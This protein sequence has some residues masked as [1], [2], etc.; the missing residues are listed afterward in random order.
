MTLTLDAFKAQLDSLL[1]AQD[2]ELSDLGRYRMIKAAVERYSSDAPD[3]YS[4]DEA[5]D[6][7]SY[8]ALTGASPVLANWIEGFSRISAIQLP[9]PTIAS[10]EAPAYLEPDDWRDDYEAGGIRYLY[11]PHHAPGAADTM[12]ITYTIPY[13]WTA[14]TAAITI[15]QTAHGLSADDYI[16]QDDNQVWH[17]APEQRVATHQI[18]TVPDVDTFTAKILEI[19]PPPRDFFA[20]CHLAASLACQAIATRY[21]R[22]TE[23]SISADSASHIARAVEF[24]ARAKEFERLYRAHLGLDTEQVHHGTAAFVDLDTAPGWPA[25]RQYLFHKNR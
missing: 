16:Y 23:S 7:G 5:G 2:S 21:S 17:E 12:R 8:Y 13:S 1:T 6:G 14:T 4:E 18:A 9:A 19:D 20:I 25:G 10:D 11:L 22:T 3:T 15:A 24:A